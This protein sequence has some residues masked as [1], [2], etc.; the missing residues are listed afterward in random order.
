MVSKKSDHSMT[1]IAQVKHE[2][3]TDINASM[4]DMEDQHA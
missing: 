3:K 1:H 4:D 2:N